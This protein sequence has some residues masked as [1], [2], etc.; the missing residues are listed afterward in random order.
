MLVATVLSQT[1]NDGSSVHFRRV[2]D[3]QAAAEFAY[4]LERFM[5]KCSFRFNPDD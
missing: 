5:V 3:K 4:Q 1:V 2:Q